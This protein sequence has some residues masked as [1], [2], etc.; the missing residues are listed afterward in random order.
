MLG[1]LEALALEVRVS[2]A[3]RDGDPT[4]VQL[5]LGGN[6]ID[7]VDP[8]KRTAIEMVRSCVRHEVANE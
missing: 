6:H 5:G 4:D 1:P 8:A 3:L 7:L 2:E